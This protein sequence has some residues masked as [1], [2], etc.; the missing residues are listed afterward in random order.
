MW[1]CELQIL[2]LLFESISANFQTKPKKLVVNAAE[3]SVLPTGRLF[4]RI[5][6]KGRI[7]SGAAWQTADFEHK[8]P[9]RGRTFKKLIPSSYPL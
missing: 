5:V 2:S 7:K 8:R 1:E 6:K 9:K 3:Q 4:G